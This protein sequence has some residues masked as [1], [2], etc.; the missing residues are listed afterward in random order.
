MQW[1]VLVCGEDGPMVGDLRPLRPRQTLE[2]AEHSSL[3]KHHATESELV[4]TS[5]PLEDHVG[6]P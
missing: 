5:T 1:N 4:Y 3:N 2:T 6:T